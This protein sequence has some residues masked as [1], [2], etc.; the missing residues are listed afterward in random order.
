MPL[1]AIG[2]LLQAIELLGT[3]SAKPFMQVCEWQSW[4]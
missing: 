4:L 1:I 2:T 3:D